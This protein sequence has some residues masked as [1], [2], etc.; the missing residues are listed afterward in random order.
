[1]SSSHVVACIGYLNLYSDLSIF[2][3]PE[4]VQPSWRLICALRLINVDL[5][6]CEDGEVLDCAVQPWREIIHGFKEEISSDNETLVRSSLLQ[7][8]N[9]LLAR[10]SEKIQELGKCRTKN[11]SEGWHDW[12]LVTIV[13]L[14]EEEQDIGHRLSEALASGHMLKF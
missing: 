5:P 10:S 3:T 12:V 14:W 4:S 7:I 8:S 1:M 2:E 11:H 9:I 6:D 13:R